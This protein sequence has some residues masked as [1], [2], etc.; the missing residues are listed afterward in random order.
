LKM[1]Q[2]LDPHNDFFGT[3]FVVFPTKKNS[4]NFYLEVYEISVQ[5]WLDLLVFLGLVSPTFPQIW[6]PKS[7]NFERVKFDWKMSIA[8]MAI[9]HRKKMLKKVDDHP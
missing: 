9:V 7:W 8:K 1:K 2:R 5:F 4:R 3:N 6:K